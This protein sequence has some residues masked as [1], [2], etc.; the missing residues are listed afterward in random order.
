MAEVLSGSS[1]FFGLLDPQR[2]AHVFMEEVREC[3]SESI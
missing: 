3:L 1:I 2:E